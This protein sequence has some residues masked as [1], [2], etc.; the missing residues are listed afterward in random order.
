MSETKESLLDKL[1][2]KMAKIML[3]SE[4]KSEA[5][6]VK[7]EIAKL[8]DGTEVEIEGDDISVLVKQEGEEVEKI[9]APVGEHT[10]EDGS[11]VI[12]QEEGKVAEVKPKAETVEAKDEKEMDLASEI[13]T[14]KKEM[15]ELKE[16]MKPKEELS[17]VETKKEEL[18]EVETKEVEELKK[19]ELSKVTHSPEKNVKSKSKLKLKSNRGTKSIV[20]SKLFS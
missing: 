6:E 3:S 10:L 2:S 16:A 7:L 18:S 19:E 1:S 13:E 8:E 11:V 12:V 14:L 4:D 5:K 9:P 17:E 15:A 20:Y